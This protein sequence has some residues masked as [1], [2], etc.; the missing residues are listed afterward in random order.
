MKFLTD[1]EI[2]RLAEAVTQKMLQRTE[3]LLN[4]KEAASHLKYK[5]VKTFQNI[6]KNFPH[7]KK[8]G[9]IYFRKSE[10]NRHINENH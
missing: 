7:T 1:H 3:D 2:D 10:L 9:K 8:N 6:Y 4:M 5:S